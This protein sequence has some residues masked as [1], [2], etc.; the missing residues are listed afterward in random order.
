MFGKLWGMKRLVRFICTDT[1][2]VNFLRARQVVIQGVL[3]FFH[4]LT[5]R[6][7]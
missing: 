1:L 6:S 3:N 2:R 4:V 5:I 7:H